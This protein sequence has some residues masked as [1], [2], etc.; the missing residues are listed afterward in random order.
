M[1]SNNSTN[2][3]PQETV[4]TPMDLTSPSSL[5]AFLAQILLILVNM[6]CNG[7]IILV[8]IKVK[9]FHLNMFNWY[10]ANL[11]V[12]D[13]MVSVDMTHSL[14]KW[15]YGRWPFGEL[16]CNVFFT[17]I[18]VAVH[19]SP[20]II[21]I[22]SLDR[23]LC[24]TIPMKYMYHHRSSKTRTL[25]MTG[26]CSSWCIVIA[27]YSILAFGWTTFTGHKDLDYESECEM[28]FIK[29]LTMN[30]VWISLTFLIP[31]VFLSYFNVQVY[32]KTK[33]Q[34]NIVSDYSRS[35]VVAQNGDSPT[36]S[37]NDME[38]EDSNMDGTDEAHV[39]NGNPREDYYSDHVQKANERRRLERQRKSI[40]L[41]AI[42]VAVFLICWLP[43]NIM[44][45]VDTLCQTCQVSVNTYVACVY[46]L[47]INSVLNPILYS[48]RNPNFRKDVMSLFYTPR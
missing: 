17:V 33:R 16:V 22:M 28:P 35:S 11:A 37:Q 42:Y 41:L 48:V 24:V 21:T 4:Y 3:T 18:Y 36:V 7:L 6:T 32:Y 23:Y 38:E 46:V 43:F 39:S 13:F 10:I 1:S 27:F 26:L 14:F 9:S 44:L 15:Y 8:F 12:A 2:E 25:V 45:L 19:M 29:N 20:F 5:V 30:L 31:L 47:D 40:I 34:A